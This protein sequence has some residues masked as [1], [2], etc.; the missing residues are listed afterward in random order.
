[1]V[2]RTLRQYAPCSGEVS[3]REHEVMVNA[4]DELPAEDK[5]IKAGGPDSDLPLMFSTGLENEA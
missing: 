3:Y 4:K 5:V 1:M 2:A